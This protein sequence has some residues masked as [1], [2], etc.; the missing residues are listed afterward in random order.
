MNPVI[1]TIDCP[2]VP[3][4]WEQI[5]P[6]N[7]RFSDPMFNFVY[8]GQGNSEHK[9]IPKVF[10]ST[11]I[12]QYK[13]G[14]F[15]VF[16]GQSGQKIFEWNLLDHFLYYCDSIGMSLP[17][18]SD[19]FRSAM[20]LVATQSMIQ[21][22]TWP[23]RIVMPLI[24]LAQH[25]GLPTRLLDW[26]GS[27]YVAAY[28]AAASVLNEDVVT[29]NE[30]LCVFALN[31]NLIEKMDGIRHVRVPGSVSQYLAAQRGSFILVDDIGTPMNKFAP[32]KCLESN[33]TGKSIAL[34][35]VTLPAKHAAELLERCNKLGFSAANIFPSYDGAA[36]A[37]LEKFNSYN[38]N[39][40]LK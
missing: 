33:L 5:S 6:F 21:G 22:G 15:D 23:P 12:D 38:F 27:S 17:N 36:S 7:K 16:V 39:D 29:D 3:E 13:R 11:V 28:F 31:L 40:K 30:K 14:V 18:D 24:A 20:S 37:A 19:E 10:R 25:H 35:K 2:D 26:T 8:R 4:F 32:D 34:T 1:E 9:L